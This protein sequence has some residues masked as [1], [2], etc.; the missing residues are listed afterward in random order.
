LPGCNRP[1]SGEPR[2]VLR[3]ELWDITPEEFR[4]YVAK[5]IPRWNAVVEAAK[6]NAQ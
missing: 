3:G 1:A 6:I 2:Q 4:A 5:E